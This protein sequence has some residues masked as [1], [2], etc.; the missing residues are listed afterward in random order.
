MTMIK[1]LEIDDNSFMAAKI[2]ELIAE[3]NKTQP[4]TYGWFQDDR[5]IGCS[6][7]YNTTM[8]LQTKTIVIELESFQD[9]DFLQEIVEKLTALI[10]DFR[11][12]NRLLLTTQSVSIK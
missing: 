12:E 7:I 9:Q 5:N 2:N 8:P 11:K 1:P 4:L 10:T 3:H 6:P